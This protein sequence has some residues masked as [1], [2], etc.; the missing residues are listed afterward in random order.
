M[1]E[2]PTTLMVVDLRELAL[3]YELT[4]EAAGDS[5]RHCSDRQTAEELHDD[6]AAL[7]GQ[8]DSSGSSA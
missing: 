6:C 4:E 1:L 2:T 3:I 8:D 7:L 5:S